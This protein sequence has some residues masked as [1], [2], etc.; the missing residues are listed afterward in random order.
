MIDE[1]TKAEQIY[2]NTEGMDLIWQKYKRLKYQYP[3]I[4]PFFSLFLTH[5]H[6]HTH[7]HIHTH[8]EITDM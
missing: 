7:T 5:T 3:F 4:D 1:E 2:M 8:T 6:T